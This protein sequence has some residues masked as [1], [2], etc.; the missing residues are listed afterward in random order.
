VHLFGF[1][2]FV[3]FV[4]Q[5]PHNKRLVRVPLDEVEERPWPLD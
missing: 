3:E 5:N 1:R 4:R 2:N